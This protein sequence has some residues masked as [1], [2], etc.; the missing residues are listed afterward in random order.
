[1]KKKV[2]YLSIRILIDINEYNT[3]EG[4]QKKISR[5]MQIV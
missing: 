3:Q 5:N 1:M 2:K 4:G